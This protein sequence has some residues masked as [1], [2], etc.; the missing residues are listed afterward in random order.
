MTPE[1]LKKHDIQVQVE[2]FNKV[3]QDSCD[4]DGETLDVDLLAENVAITIQE[5]EKQA[6][7]E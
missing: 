3:W 6:G 4:M 1:E 2:A 5:L 7:V